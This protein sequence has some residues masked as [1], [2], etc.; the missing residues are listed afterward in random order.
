MSKKLFYFTAKWCGPCQQIK[1][2][3]YELES[4]YS[5]ISFSAIDVDLNPS[6]AEKYSIK[7]L[8]TF[9]AVVDQ[10]EFKRFSKADPEKLRALVADLN[11]V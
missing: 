4:K 6:F 9:V 10:T 2:V 11:Q 5:D 8:P 3:F 7:Q 1:P